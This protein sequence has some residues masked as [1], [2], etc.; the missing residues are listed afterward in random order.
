MY[1]NTTGRL[2]CNAIHDL[3]A[4]LDGPGRGVVNE[5]GGSGAPR[6]AGES[7]ERLGRVVSLD[8]H[9]DAAVPARIRIRRL[10]I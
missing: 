10:D 6:V 2:Q 9:V 8:A 4:V 3:L 1:Y 7:H 5:Q